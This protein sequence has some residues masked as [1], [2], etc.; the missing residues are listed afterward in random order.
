MIT[1]TPTAT[2]I[3]ATTMNNID[4]TPAEFNISNSIQ[5]QPLQQSSLASNC[6]FEIINLDIASKLNSQVLAVTATILIIITVIPNALVAAAM[7]STKQY[8]LR[9]P[10]HVLLLVLS[11][12]DLL[13]GIIVS[14]PLLSNTVMY[15][16]SLSLQRNIQTIF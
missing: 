4:S 13:I 15:N 6:L 10:S 8:R 7:I 1:P 16:S 3:E 14:H 9:S 11:T 5:L 2:T 12:C